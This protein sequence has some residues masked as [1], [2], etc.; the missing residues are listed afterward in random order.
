[1]SYTWDWGN[2]RS[3]TKP[4]PTDKNFWPNTGVYTVTLTVTDAGNLTGSTSKQVTIGTPPPNQPP[5]ANITSPTA[6][7]SF[8]QGT[9]VSF[10]GTGTDPEDGAL[11]GASLTWSSSRDG[12]IGTGTSFSKTNLSVGTH[13]ITLTAKD[14]QGATGTATVTITITAPNQ[15]PTANITSPTANASFVQGHLSVSF[16]PARAGSRRWYAHGCIAHWCRAA[17]RDGAIGTGTSFSKTNL[18]VGTHVITLTAT[19]SKSATGTATVT[20]TITAPNQP[21]TANIRVAHDEPE[22]PAGNL[23]VVCGNGE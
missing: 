3:E 19:D 5:T 21:P 17:S 8:V 9:S 1:M 10:A 7:Q 13:V 20:I 2:G 16:L 18:S 23:G 11:T 12:A 22:L 14:S 6:N 4:G 15:P